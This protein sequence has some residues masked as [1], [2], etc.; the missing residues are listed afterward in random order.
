MPHERL[1]LK[2]DFYGIRGNL[3]LWIR[4][5]LTGRHQQVVLNGSTSNQVPVTSGVPQG[6]V[7]GPLL[8]LVFINDLPDNVSSNV[9]LFADDCLLYRRINTPEDTCTNISTGNL[10]MRG[11]S[12]KR[13]TPPQKGDRGPPLK[14]V[15]FTLHHDLQ[16][17]EPKLQ[18]VTMMSMKVHVSSLHAPIYRNFYLCIGK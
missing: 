14:S 12:L 4:E 5:I 9:R 2:L 3:L 17:K 1:L 11:T 6:T 15:L 13:G 16:E 7:L 8:F 10:L 18:K